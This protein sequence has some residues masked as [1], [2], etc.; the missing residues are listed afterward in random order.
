MFK[1]HQL[2]CQTTKKD[3]KSYEE[4]NAVQ[5]RAQKI[6]EQRALRPMKVASNPVPDISR[7]D[8]IAAQAEDPSLQRLRDLASSG[9]EKLTGKQ[10]TVRFYRSRGLLYRQF[11]S[12]R[13]E[14]GDSLQQL[15]VPEKYRKH[16][17]TLAHDSILGGHQGVKKTSDKI[18]SSFFWPGLQSDV[19]RFCRSCDVCQRTIH[20]GRVKRV[21][22]GIMPLI[23][24]PFQRIAVDIVGPIKPVTTKGHRYILTIVD[25][26]TRY[27]EAVP[28]RNIETTRV[29]EALVDVFSRVGVPREVLTDQGSQFTSN[30]MREVSR[31]LSVRQLTTTPYHP[32]CNGLVERFNGTLKQMLKRMCAERPQDWDRYINPLL[33]AYRETPQASLGFSPF[34]LLYGRS[35]RGPMSILKEL[36]SGD[37]DVPE[38]RSTYQFVIDLRDRLEQTCKLARD[39]L[40]KS[41][42][43]MRRYYNRG[44]R[45]R[46]FNVGDLVLLL[47]PTDHNKLLM[48][49]KGPFPVI[50]K[51]GDMDYRVRIGSGVK[52]FHA[53]LLKRYVARN[54]VETSESTMPGKRDAMEVVCCAVIS[55]D[56]DDSGTTQ[57]SDHVYSNADDI[58]LPVV[59]AHESPSDV[60][61]RLELSTEQNK[62]VCRLLP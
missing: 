52:V 56:E 5:T 11:R 58:E 21:P 46:K 13:V 7:D 42:A 38:V 55:D 61:I 62:Q 31:L 37:V 30:V 28:L 18:L 15:V 57:P 50:E 54:E 39:E 14:F 23:E 49:W 43:R 27:P 29:A 19:T 22:L 35:V 8:F 34:E 6:A 26:A 59:E 60:A 33:F 51:V 41:S 32:A 3:N 16:V 36:W 9:D 2:S 53:N 4:V 44:A 47:L 10:N 17:M 48:Q 40:G 24:V 12:P 20:K 1:K 45:A 25:Y